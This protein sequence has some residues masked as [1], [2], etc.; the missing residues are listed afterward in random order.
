MTTLTETQATAIINWYDTIGTRNWGTWGN[1]PS[2]GVGASYHSFENCPCR[3]KFDTLIEIDGHAYQ[4]IADVRNQLV[5]GAGDYMHIE[6]LK[7]LFI[8]GYNDAKNA[9]IKDSEEA[10]FLNFDYGKF[11]EIVK[12]YPNDGNKKTR[13]NFEQNALKESGFIKRDDVSS[14]W[15][16]HLA[17][18]K[19]GI[20]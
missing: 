1:Y 13:R 8:D 17:S 6:T 5:P 15:G 14:S 9:K 10:C 11:A 20:K 2:I 18:K 7:E 3:I 4:G 19:I 12:Q 16:Y